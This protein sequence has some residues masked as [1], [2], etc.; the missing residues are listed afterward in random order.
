MNINEID[1]EIKERNIT[2]LC[3]FVHT[4]LL[5]HI[6]NSEEGIKAVN[7]IDKDILKQND[8]QRLDGKKDYVNCSIQYPNYWY[9]RRVK[10]N[11]PVFPDWAIIF[12]DPIVIAYETTEFCSVN[13]ATRYGA[14]IEKGYAAFKDMFSNKIDIGNKVHN[15]SGMMLKSAPTDDQ[16][17]A[18]VYKSIPRKFI[19]GIALMSEEAAREKK[20]AWDVLGVPDIDIYIAPELFSRTASDKI[21][22]GILPEEYKYMED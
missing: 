20:A 13:A 4:N 8:E 6:L 1:I 16:A 5:L 22:Q 3:H 17:E 11:N 14:Y 15:R 7:F 9:F 21:R 2:R 19:T 12:I 18:L 10:D